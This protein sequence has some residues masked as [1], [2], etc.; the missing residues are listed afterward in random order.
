MPEVME[1]M[2]AVPAPDWGAWEPLA[3]GLLTAGAAALCLAGILSVFGRGGRT[4]RP[5]ALAALAAGLCGQA[6]L[7]VSLEQPLRAYEFFLHPSFTSWT[8]AGAYIV[9]V[10]LLC[11]ALLVLASRGARPVARSLAALAAAGL[12]VFVYA[13]NE[14]MACVGRELWTGPLVP[15]LFV[16][17]GLSGG[18]GLAA[19]FAAGARVPGSPDAASR[20]LAGFAA[21]AVAGCTVLAVILPAPAGFAAVVSPWWHAPGAL[22]LL[23]A[24]VALAGWRGGGRGAYAAG[25]A[26]LAGGFLLFWKL[27]QLGQAFPRNAATVADRAAFLDLA[28]GPSLLAIAGT[29]GLLL[30]LC[31][32]L[33][34]V[35]PEKPSH[36]PQGVR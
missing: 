24:C 9:P 4:V 6:A 14:I 13:T 20:V 33:P 17:A 32:L 12:A 1:L 8:A 21:L 10:F 3:L 2:G 16:V 15:P 29:S 27:V 22:C 28:S 31:L 19:C 30:A 34:V 35:A 36:A 25:I 18:L 5:L 26:G 11:A 23:T 7:F